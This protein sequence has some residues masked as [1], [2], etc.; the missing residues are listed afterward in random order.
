[1]FALEGSVDYGQINLERG[2]GAQLTVHRNVT[3]A[4]FD[5]TV[6]HGEAKPGPL[7]FFFRSEERLEDLFPRDGVHSNAG[8]AH[9]EAN[10]GAEFNRIRRLLGKDLVDFDIAG[11][12]NQFP[13]VWHSIPR[14]HRKIQDHLLNLSL[15][16]LYSA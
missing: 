10:V 9:S 13:P 11:F 8:I 7:P 16:R 4:L 12:D 1:M 14:V 2:A 15:I 5:D 3:T 6:N